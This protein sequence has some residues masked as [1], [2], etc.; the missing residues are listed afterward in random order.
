MNIHWAARYP[1]ITWGRSQYSLLPHTQTH[2]TYKKYY[3]C[4]NI[5]WK[6]LRNR[7]KTQTN[8]TETKTHNIRWNFLSETGWNSL[9]LHTQA[10]TTE[11]KTHTILLTF[12]PEGIPIP[13]SHRCVCTMYILHKYQNMWWLYYST[14]HL[15]SSHNIILKCYEVHT[16]SRGEAKLP[17]YI[18]DFSQAVSYT[19]LTLPTKA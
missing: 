3:C 17:I 6:C 18:I 10:H 13:L 4:D 7:I 2:T 8:T 9:L 1:A 15:R 16:K 14:D 11:T 19:H 5:L 12:L